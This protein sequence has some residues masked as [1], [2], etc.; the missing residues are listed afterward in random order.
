MARGIS[1][2]LTHTGKAG[3]SIHLD[4]LRGGLDRTALHRK[5]GP[6]YV[7]KNQSVELAYSG[8]VAISLERGAIRSFVDEGYLTYDFI[9]SQQF[10][11]ALAVPLHAETHL[12]GEPDQIDADKLRIA[13]APTNYAPDDSTPTANNSDELAA[14]LKGIDNALLGGGGGGTTT[15]PY[16]LNVDFSVPQG[17]ILYL[18]VGEVATSAAP[19]VLRAPG[20]LQGASIKVNAS[21]ADRTYTLR[22]LLNGVVV[23]NLVLTSG[24]DQAF[25]NAFSQAF[26]AGDVLSCYLESTAGPVGKST[27]SQVSATIFTVE[28]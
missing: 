15:F 22:V 12:R 4:D 26:V 17:S 3:G 19:I 16:Q 21:D 1:V 8:L 5:P 27:F 7:P 14:H 24:Q 25:N 9:L 13:F 6:V 2:R 11:D 20:V 18:R 23:E 10:L 28:P